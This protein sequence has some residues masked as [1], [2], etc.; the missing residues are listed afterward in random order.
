MDLSATTS[1]DA[2]LVFVIHPI[3][4]PQLKRP[5]FTNLRLVQNPEV[6]FLRYRFL[7]VSGKML[8]HIDNKNSELFLIPFY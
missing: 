7:C 3:K 4:S 1:R 2:R 5:N 6:P 8:T